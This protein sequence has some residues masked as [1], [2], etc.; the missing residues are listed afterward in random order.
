MLA[1]GQGNSDDLFD[2]MQYGL[3]LAALLVAGILHWLV[4][5]ASISVQQKPK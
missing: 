4:G 1:T 2:P 5:N 3:I